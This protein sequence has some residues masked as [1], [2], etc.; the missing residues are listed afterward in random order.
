[1]N[2]NFKLWIEGIEEYTPYQ[3]LVSRFASNRYFPFKNWFPQERIYVPFGKDIV[4]PEEK[5]YQEELADLLND[6]GYELVDLRQGYA[7][8]KGKQNLYKIVKLL[9]KLQYEEEKKIQ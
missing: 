4:T 2:I 5:K 7:R 6:S 3:G 8:Q 1:M 9:N